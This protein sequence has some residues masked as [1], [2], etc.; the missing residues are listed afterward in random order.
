MKAYPLLQMVIHV[1]STWSNV[2]ECRHA[3]LH[4]DLSGDFFF[5]IKAIVKNVKNK[6]I[7]YTFCTDIY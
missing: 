3:C 7:K 2:K 4:A 1:Y 5:L 6:S